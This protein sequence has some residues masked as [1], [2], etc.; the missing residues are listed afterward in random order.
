MSFSKDIR[1]NLNPDIW[2]PFGW[3]FND[4]ICLSY[5]ENPTQNEKQHYINFFYA[6]PY[7]LPCTKCRNHFNQYITKYPLNDNI[8]QSKENLIKWFLGAHNNINRINNKKLITLEEFYLYYNKKFN[9]DV[10]KDT[11]KI[12][13]DLK[14]NIPNL[15]KVNNTNNTN[16]TKNDFKI[17]SI[18]LFGIVIA[19]SLYVLRKNHLS[20]N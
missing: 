1:T 6:L 15:K 19:L 20:I 11:C 16:N 13:C 18:I 10:K 3:F 9:M 8:L 5:P 17:I 12:T 14:Q 4:S 7:I 2:G